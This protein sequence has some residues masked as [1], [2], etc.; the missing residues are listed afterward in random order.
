VIS[1]LDVVV[2]GLGYIGLPTATALATRGVNVVGV[3]VNPAVVDAVNTGDSPFSEP[4]LDEA[5]AEAVAAGRLRARLTTPTADVFIIA[6]PTPIGADR[7]ADLS[8]VDAAVAQIVPVLKGGELV[9]LESTCPPGTT[10]RLAEW[11]VS[12]RPDLSVA[13]E[14]GDS[15]VHVAYCPERVLPGR[16]MTELVENDRVIGGLTPMAAAHARKVYET[17]CEGLI[18]TTDATT[19][20]LVKLVENS[21]R[22]VNIAFANEISMIA[23]QLGVDTHE[24]IGLA[25]HHPRVNILSPGPGVGGHCIA[26][27]PWFLISAAPGVSNLIRTARE[28]NLH[29]TSHVVRRVV[30]AVRSSPKPRIAVLGIAFKADVGDLRESPACVVVASLAEALP[31]AEL[32]VVDPHVQELPPSLAV[33]HNVTLGGLDASVAGADLV[34]LLVDH[35]AFRVADRSAWRLDEKAVID[36]RG[37]WR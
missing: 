36:T 34:V 12:E 30:E 32:R 19:A 6:V 7:A 10:A 37:A 4:G 35:A 17:F 25:N 27:D 16:I 18:L 5:L 20:E 21:Y 29:K 3:D 1:E 31:E 15:A 22:D 13:A 14:E 23:E 28:V 24:L 33:W 2:V 26:V 9:V 8:F 11:L